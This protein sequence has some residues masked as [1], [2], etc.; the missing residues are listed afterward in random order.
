MWHPQKPRQGDRIS[1]KEDFPSPLSIK[2][3]DSVKTLRA[4]PRI[5]VDREAV[6]ASDDIAFHRRPGR[7]V[8]GVLVLDAVR[9]ARNGHETDCI[10]AVWHGR[11]CRHLW[12]R[13][14]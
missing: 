6:I 2:H 3:K 14:N 7:F 9:L 13:G 10:T 11:D 12:T 8:E 1:A 4:A 5:V